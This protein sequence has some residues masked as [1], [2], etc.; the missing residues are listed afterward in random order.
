MKIR[1]LATPPEIPVGIL[2]G[3]QNKKF[4]VTEYLGKDNQGQGNS[5]NFE[6][7]TKEKGYN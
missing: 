2:G 3:K 1:N 6:E 7:L 4:L 5:S